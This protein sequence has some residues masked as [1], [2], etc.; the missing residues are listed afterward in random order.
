MLTGKQ[1]TK[2]L[3]EKDTPV[4]MIQKNG[5]FHSLEESEENLSAKQQATF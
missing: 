1:R 5:V 2:N 4:I 3:R